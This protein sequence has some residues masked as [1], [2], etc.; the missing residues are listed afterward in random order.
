MIQLFSTN[1]PPSN[2]PITDQSG[3]MSNAGM[4][5][6]RALWNRTGQN[7]GSLYTSGDTLSSIGNS[8]ATALTLSADWN[9][10]TTVSPGTGVL[11]PAL[12]AGQMV[13]VFNNDPANDLYVYP[14]SGASITYQSVNPGVN[15]PIK[16]AFASLAAIFYFSNTSI[17]AA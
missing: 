3:N 2:T 15:N 12:T 8:Q 11:L 17:V 4:A 7:S 9:N 6:F 16:V 14:P 1:F 13:W 10:I 5:F